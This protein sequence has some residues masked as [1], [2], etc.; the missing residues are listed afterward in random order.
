MWVYLAKTKIKRKNHHKKN[1][2]FRVFVLFLSCGAT[3]ITDLR[4][5]F[6]P[7]N[8]T[9]TDEN[10]KLEQK[11]KIFFLENIFYSTDFVDWFLDFSYAFAHYIGI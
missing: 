5:R 10:L 11:K 3:P 9:Q 7:S 2:S 6:R 1:V 8:V 4:K